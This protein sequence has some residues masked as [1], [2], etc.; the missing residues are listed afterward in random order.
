MRPSAAWAPERWS[1]EFASV[2]HH[3]HQHSCVPQDADLF[4]SIRS[5][6]TKN[7]RP[8]G[9]WSGKANSEHDPLLE[10]NAS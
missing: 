9:Q 8:M 7:I 1:A 3:L 4:E 5:S 2:Q 10:A 6:L